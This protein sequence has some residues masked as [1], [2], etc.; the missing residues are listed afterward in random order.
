[1]ELSS[2]PGSTYYLSLAAQTRLDEAKVQT[3]FA[4]YGAY[5]NFYQPGY[6]SL[7]RLQ[8][9]LQRGS[10]TRE[11]IRRWQGSVLSLTGASDLSLHE[12]VCTDT[13]GAGI[14]EALCNPPGDTQL[15]IVLWNIEDSWDYA[16]CDALIDFVGLVLKLDPRVF[17]AVLAS[18]EHS[19][20]A[21]WSDE[22]RYHPTHATIGGLVATVCESPYQNGTIPVVLVIGRLNSYSTVH[23]YADGSVASDLFAC[24]WMNMRGLDRIRPSP[25]FELGR[26][27][28]AVKLNWPC[29]RTPYRILLTEMLQKNRNL[30]GHTFTLPLVCFV[31]L[32]QMRL[33]ELRCNC[34]Y[35][36][37]LL[38]RVSWNKRV[39]DGNDL[40]D[41]HIKLRHL[42]D[43]IKN[44]WCS[45]VKFVKRWK[46]YDWSKEQ[47]YRELEAETKEVL[48]EAD[49]LGSQIRDD[50]QLEAGKLGLEESRKSI[51]MSNRQI[52]EAKRG[53]HRP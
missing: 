15:Q 7:G 12:C 22:D 46:L 26:S 43:Q 14:V 49:G 45:F 52:E 51:E 18:A 9:R 4:T 53:E 31:P 35:Y 27:S 24:R 23:P 2:Y 30:R 16:Y 21:G 29:Y 13:Q 20:E 17:E 34:S 33:S 25:P 1:M 39:H 10:K 42:T 44:D 37:R 47:L 36:R 11:N 50:I 19:H 48:A 8:R 32:L 38:R 6:P 41:S 3:G 40:Y 28:S 5:L